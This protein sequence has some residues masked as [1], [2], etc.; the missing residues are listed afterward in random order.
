M[1][2]NLDRRVEAVA[3]VEDPAL[4]ARLD[5]IIEASLDDDVLSWELDAD[6]SWHKVDPARG[7]DAQERLMA[8]AVERGRGGR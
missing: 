5:E 7:V 8:L 3:P 1:P 4:R 6:G 2:R